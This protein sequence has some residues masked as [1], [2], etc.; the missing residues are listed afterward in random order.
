M[1]S[2][3]LVLIDT[4]AAGLCSS[5]RVVDAPSRRAHIVLGPPL[6]TNHRFLFAWTAPGTE[7]CLG[8]IRARGNSP[9]GFD[10][11]SRTSP[12]PP[13]ALILMGG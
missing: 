10:W 13:V 4:V 7:S 9:W 6:W 3:L 1:V 5:R 8:L 11:F 12:V 2:N